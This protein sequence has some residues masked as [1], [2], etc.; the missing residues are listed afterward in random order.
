MQTVGKRGKDHRRAFFMIT[1]FF[2]ITI[3]IISKHTTLCLPI[4]YSMKLV[5]V[6]NTIHYVGLARYFKKKE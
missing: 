3:I 2:I 4:S 5:N 1:L 6:K